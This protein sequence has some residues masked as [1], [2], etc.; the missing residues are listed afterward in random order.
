MCIKTVEKNGFSAMRFVFCF[1]DMRFICALVSYCCE[2][3][4]FFVY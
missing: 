3:Y 2:M 1:L 4:N